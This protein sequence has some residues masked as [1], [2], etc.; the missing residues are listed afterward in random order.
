M[1]L[2][3]QDDGVLVIAELSGNHNGSEERALA[4]VRAAKEAGAD[5]V[6]LQT[7]TADTITMDADG[8][9][10][11]IKGGPWG[12]RKLYDLYGEAS[13]PWEWHAALFAEARRLGMLCFSS[14]FDSTAVD[15]LESLESPCYKV[16][17]FEVVDIPL[18][19]K[20]AQTRKP[21]IMS[22]GMATDGEIEEAVATLRQGGTPE[23]ALLSCVSAYP[24]P[25]EEYRLRNVAELSRRFGCTAGLSDHTLTSTVAIAAVALGARIVE[26]HLCLRRTDGGPDAAFSLEP[27][28]FRSLVAAVRDVQAGMRAPLGFGPGSAELANVA[29]RKSLFAARDI[30]RGTILT[31]DDV[32]CIRPGHGI[33][34]RELRRVVGSRSLADIRR[35][36]PLSWDLLRPCSERSSSRS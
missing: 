31:S 28:E 26:K 32:R 3:T 24:A 23:V 36:T 9:W 15:F 13:T 25:A 4:L 2:P 16:A 11:T 12:G 18:L 14:P 7:Y 10:F 27:S 8:D 21:V 29:F 6:K 34:P 30:P 5:A 20:V 35:G 22:T 33:K 19:E 17:S 1:K